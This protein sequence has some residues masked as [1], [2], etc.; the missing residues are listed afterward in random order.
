MDLHH[1]DYLTEEP[2]T[3]GDMS[4]TSRGVTSVI[5]EKPVISG[6]ASMTWATDMM[7]STNTRKSVKKR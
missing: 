7:S 3:V 4:V 5:G 1:D 2:A 6:E